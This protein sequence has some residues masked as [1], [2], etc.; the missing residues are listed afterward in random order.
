MTLYKD[1][2]PY[3]DQFTHVY[4]LNLGILWSPLKF[5][6]CQFWAPSLKN[7]WYHKRTRPPSPI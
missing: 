6:N 5:Y 3:V 1:I 4:T 2:M 7:E